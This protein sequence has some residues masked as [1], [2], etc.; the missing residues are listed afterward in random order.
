MHRISLIL[1]TPKLVASP[2]APM[3]AVLVWLLKRRTTNSWRI[4]L[5]KLA[6][7]RLVRNRM[8]RWRD[9]RSWM[10]R[11]RRWRVTYPLNSQS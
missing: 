3:L 9:P 10:R 6:P 5:K 8:Y 2:H 7:Y 4:R 1:S 11:M